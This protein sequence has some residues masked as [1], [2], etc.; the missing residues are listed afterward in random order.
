MPQAEAGIAALLSNP[1]FL[2]ITE[3]VN[4]LPYGVSHLGKIVKNGQIVS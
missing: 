1:T 2:D 4:N 3:M